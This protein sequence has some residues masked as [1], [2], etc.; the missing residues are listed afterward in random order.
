MAEFKKKS[1]Q[2]SQHRYTLVAW[3]QRDKNIPCPN[4]G[5]RHGQYKEYIDTWTGQVVDPVGHT[6]GR[7][8]SETK[9][10]YNLTPKQFL[11]GQ[12]KVKPIQRTE[13]LKRIEIDPK[14]VGRYFRNTKQK[15]NNLLKWVESLP[16]SEAQRSCIPDLM[17]MYAVGTTKDGRVIWWQIDEERVVR[18]GKIM[19]Y[20]D[21]GHRQKGSDG[22][23]VGMGWVHSMLRSKGMIPK[24]GYDLVQCL[25]GQHLLAILPDAE[26]HLVESEKSA[27]VMSIIDKYAMCDHIWLATGGLYNLRESTFVALRGR[28]VICY[29]DAD[30]VEKWKEKVNGRKG[31]H[32][33]T[34]WMDGIPD[35]EHSK[36]DILD[37]TISAMGDQRPTKPA[38]DEEKLTKL[39]VDYPAVDLLINKLNLEQMRK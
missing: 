14:L 27:F 23:S 9:C 12:A 37:V 31:W 36:A 25:F 34:R 10:G 17:K 21:D 33:S 39:R 1:L 24:D 13:P 4:C 16:L 19:A 38:T 8:D 26:V 7:C 32:L 20:A 29:P 5:K 30:G 22:Q 6:C 18:T 2:P 15:G 35:R 3:A 11:Q 28:T